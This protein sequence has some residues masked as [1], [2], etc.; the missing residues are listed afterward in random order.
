MKKVVLFL[1]SIIFV[2]CFPVNMT[3]S[4]LHAQKTYYGRALT[5]GVFLYSSPNV[6]SD[7][8]NAIFEI[9]TTYFVE[10]LSDE[11]ELFYKA[12][13]IDV[14]GYVKKTDVSCID[15]VPQTPFA[16]DI[17]FRV[18]VPSGVNLRQSPNESYGAINLITSIPYL[19]TNLVYYGTIQGEEA[20]TY[21]GSTWFYCRYIKANQSYY[22]YVYS[23]LCDLL[24][25]IPQNIENYEYVTPDF[26]D[27][28]ST[29]TEPINAIN[30]GTPLQ[31]AIIAGVS[32]PCIFIVYLLFKP[33]KI[34]M[35]TVS[36]NP[37]KNSRRTTS[38]KKKK[39]KR[40]KHSD[41]YE[42]DSDYF[43]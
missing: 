28:V 19:E 25:S 9:P 14:Y 38:K 22:G 39:I 24:P 21:K 1:T 33:T 42:L 17:G 10:L 30:F 41:Y 6:L 34:S 13:Y 31:I 20:I 11:N 26:S 37:T 12:R 32:L 27:P 4:F 18:F 16:K 7:N 40:L 36:N 29:Q 2:F 23:P 35:Q 5:N 15:V 3:K 43:D 8:S